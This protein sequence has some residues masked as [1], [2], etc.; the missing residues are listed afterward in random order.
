MQLGVYRNVGQNC[1]D[2][3]GLAALV[4][5]CSGISH[6][7][8]MFSHECHV[9]SQAKLS[10][11]IPLKTNSRSRIQRRTRLTQVNICVSVKIGGIHAT[12]MFARSCIKCRFQKRG[13]FQLSARSASRRMPP[14]DPSARGPV[15]LLPLYAHHVGAVSGSG[16]MGMPA[17]R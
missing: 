15:G 6:V 11:R 9:S 12:F 3:L 13:L 14:H 4:H 7:I 16:S 2:A 5:C 17:Q 10:T 1:A 8:C